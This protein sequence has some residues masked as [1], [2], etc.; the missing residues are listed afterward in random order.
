MADF[1]LTNGDPGCTSATDTSEIDGQC[2]DLADNDGDT[3]TDFGTT[4]TKD[5]KCTS[6]SD[7]DE[8]P[9]DNCGD[10][11]NGITPG[12]QGTVSGDDESVPFSLTDFCIDTAT[13]NEYHCGALQQDYAPLSTTFTC[14]NTC[15]N[16]TC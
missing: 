2:D 11:D 14:N 10:S 15:S 1:R 12:I 5:S 7:N 6:F 8:S 13:L 4:N 3:K 16:G 9:R